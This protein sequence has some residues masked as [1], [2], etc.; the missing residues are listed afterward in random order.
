M[1]TGFLWCRAGNLRGSEHGNKLLGTVK[2]G[3][4][5]DQLRDGQFLKDN[6]A[7]ILLDLN[8]NFTLWCNFFL[9]KK[10]TRLSCK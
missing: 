10:M 6:A 5:L 9:E 1:R 8:K 4:F 7:R 3:D 2:D